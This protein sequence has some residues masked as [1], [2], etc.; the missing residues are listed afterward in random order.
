M[1][2]YAGR[3]IITETEVGVYHCVSRCVRRDFL[4]GQEALTGRS[5]EHLKGWIQSR[6]EE[7]AGIFA[8]DVLG[9]SVMCN[10]IHQLL[11][12]RPDVAAAWSD[13]EVARRWWRLHPGR[14]NEDGTPAMPEP[15][16]IACLQIDAEALAQRRRRLSSVSWWTRSLCEPVAR[17]ANREDR[18]TGRFFDGRFKCQAILDESALLSVDQRRCL[19]RHDKLLWPL[20]PSRGGSAAEHGGSRRTIGQ[21]LVPRASVQPN[22]L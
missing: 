20:V 6:L 12:N 16:E 15:H 2:A 11:R 5:F 13:E 17:R 1:P 9:F 8:V 21:A 10:H 4:C 3:E 19:A 18:V 7:L 14:R 22:G